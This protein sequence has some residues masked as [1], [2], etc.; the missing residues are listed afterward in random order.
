MY[1]F[2]HVELTQIGYISEPVIDVRVCADEREGVGRGVVIGVGDLDASQVP[3]DGQA[4]D[5]YL[6][7]R[8]EELEDEEAGVAVDP[9][10]V[11]PAEGDH[12]DGTREAGR[13]VHLVAL[14]GGGEGGH[15]VG[16]W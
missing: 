9:H 16:S 14:A 5:D 12:V 7:G 10:E 6:E 13:Q 8:D 3:A 1:K 2:P 11:L 15:G 4:E